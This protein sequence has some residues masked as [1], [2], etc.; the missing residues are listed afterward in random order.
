[1]R[2]VQPPPGPDADLDPVGAAID[3]EARA[4]GGRDVAG[5]DLDVGKRRRNSR[6]ARSITTECPCAMSMTSTST[7]ARTSS[8]GALEV[9]AGRA[10]RRANHQP[11]LRVAGRERAALLTDQVLAP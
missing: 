1:M 4:L 8:R 6:M 9:I 11:S 10:D 5:N 3:Q 2:V 7:P